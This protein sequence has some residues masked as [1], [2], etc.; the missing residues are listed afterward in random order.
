MGDYQK[1]YN[2][3]LADP[4]GFWGKW[5]QNWTDRPWNAVKEW[6]YPYAKWF[7]NAQTQHHRKLS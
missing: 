7:I 2:D 3:F 4:D 5:P 1:T 6:N